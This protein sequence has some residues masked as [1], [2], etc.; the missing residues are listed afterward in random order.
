MAEIHGKCDQRTG[1]LNDHM[2]ETNRPRRGHFQCQPA[3]VSDEVWYSTA[4]AWV[5]AWG[6]DLY[7]AVRAAECN[8]PS[9]DMDGPVARTYVALVMIGRALDLDRQNKDPALNAALDFVLLPR[10]IQVAAQGFNNP[11][12]GRTLQDAIWLRWSWMFPYMTLR[13][14]I[15]ECHRKI[16]LSRID[17]PTIRRWYQDV[18]RQV[19]EH[20]LRETSQAD[21][22][23]QRMFKRTAQQLGIDWSDI[24]RSSYDEQRNVFQA[25]YDSILAHPI[26][27]QMPDEARIELGNLLGRQFQAKRDEIAREEILKVTAPKADKKTQAG[28]LKA[29]PRIVKWANLG[30]LDDAHFPCSGWLRLIRQSWKRPLP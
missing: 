23:V 17:A 6:S 21:T 11:I 27:G 26:L 24:L 25:I 16:A 18:R 19:V 29:L 22:I 14:V 13:S 30:M 7:G 8:D 3:T 28:I 12:V 20:V 5:D 2:S 15:W 9:A 10:M 1:A 4:V